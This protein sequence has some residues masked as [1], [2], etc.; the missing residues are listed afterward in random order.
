MA[1]VFVQCTARNTGWS[2]PAPPSMLSCVRSDPNNAPARRSTQD[3]T[4]TA[5]KKKDNQDDRI[6][7][8]HRMEYSVYE[9]LPVQG[10]PSVRRCLGG[11]NF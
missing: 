6:R 7:A 5:A 3:S 9:R 11:V 1:A 10:M 2:T 4:I 8:V